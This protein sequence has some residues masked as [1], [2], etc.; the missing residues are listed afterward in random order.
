MTPTAKREL[1]VL[2]SLILI[3]VTLFIIEKGYLYYQHRLL[4]NTVYQE[5]L[6]QKIDLQS[7]LYLFKDYWNTNRSPFVQMS[8]NL[9]DSSKKS[10][11]AY[12]NNFHKKVNNAL[13]V[14]YDR[15]DLIPDFFELIAI[16]VLIILYPLR[17]IIRWSRLLYF[18]LKI[19]EPE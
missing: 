9:P 19:K 7:E 3:L 4:V 18:R 2:A 17:L 14:Y 16:V 1:R 11:T 6:S 13:I 8:F 12:V 15:T 5:N 10:D